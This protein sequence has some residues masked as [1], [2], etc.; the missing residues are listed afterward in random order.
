MAKKQGSTNPPSRPHLLRRAE[1]LQQIAREL[2][3]QARLGR[4]KGL[5]PARYLRLSTD[6]PAILT[7]GELGE[8]LDIAW[9][10]ARRE[11]ISCLFNGE[12]LK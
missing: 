6:A 8:L 1:R 12:S 9:D 5:D 10:A 7:S 3:K 2:L 4:G 11:A